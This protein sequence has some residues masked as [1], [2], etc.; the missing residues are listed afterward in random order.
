MWKFVSL[1]DFYL[2]SG[3][4]S[5]ERLHKID[6]N[7][8]SFSKFEKAKYFLKNEGRVLS[9]HIRTIF[10]KWNLHADRG[11]GVRFSASIS[12]KIDQKLNLPAPQIQ[13]FHNCRTIKMLLSKSYIFKTLI[14]VFETNHLKKQS[15][16]NMSSSVN[17][18]STCRC[19]IW[20]EKPI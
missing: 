18:S 13:L 6:Q 10:Q 14:N 12:A 15:V 2:D 4:T 5:L 3:P 16:H 8:I 9:Y 11:E 17:E 7:S 19:S 1:P 20:K